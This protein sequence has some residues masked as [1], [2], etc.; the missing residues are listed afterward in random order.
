[1]RVER[2]ASSH[3][4]AGIRLHS[5]LGDIRDRNDVDRAINQ[6]L[7]HGSITSDPDDPCGIDMVDKYVRQPIMNPDS[8]VA[9]WF[10]PANKVYSERTITSAS[11]NLWDEDGIENLRPDRIV[12]RPDGT[13][14]VID[15]KSGERNDKKYCRQVKRYIDRLRLVFP[16][17]DISGRI[18]Y[19][20]RDVILD[21]NGKVL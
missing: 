7:K 13:I 8:R 16:D 2:A 12:R 17:A 21:H 6:G 3:I 1:M 19:I 11:D 5:L 4:K 15:Y 20:T 14:L 9:A 18:W 10:D